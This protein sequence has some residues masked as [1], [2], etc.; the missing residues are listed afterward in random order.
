MSSATI[1]YH[2]QSDLAQHSSDIPELTHHLTNTLCSSYHLLS[3]K[4]LNNSLH[5]HNTSYMKTEHKL[6]PF[7]NVLTVKLCL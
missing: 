2:I 1:T 3:Q 5:I 4:L 7:K 6:F